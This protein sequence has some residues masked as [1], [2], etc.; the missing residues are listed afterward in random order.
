M[1]ETRQDT[2]DMHLVT[3]WI[4]QDADVAAI[5]AEGMPSPA[6]HA[7]ETEEIDIAMIIERA[8]SWVVGFKDQWQ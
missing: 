6:I 2:T 8:Q 7:W 1:V 5:Y 3:R 4:A